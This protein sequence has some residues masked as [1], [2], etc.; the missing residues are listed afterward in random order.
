MTDET[1]LLFSSALDFFF[2]I[3]FSDN[4]YVLVN[5]TLW[6]HHVDPPDLPFSAYLKQFYSRR[7]QKRTFSTK[8]LSELSSM[9]FY[10]TCPFLQRF[11]SI[12]LEFE[13]ISKSTKNTDFFGILGEYMANM[14]NLEKLGESCPVVKMS[15]GTPVPMGRCV[16]NP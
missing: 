15:C 1:D 16:D 6:Y 2:Q 9:C 7:A 10:R 4:I 14:R 11:I 5:Q 12:F 13:I 3:I 8:E